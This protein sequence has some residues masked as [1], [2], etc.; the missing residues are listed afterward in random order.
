MDYLQ[1][2]Y[3]TVTT[4]RSKLRHDDALDNQLE[5]ILNHRQ[6][7]DTTYEPQLNTL[8]K[9]YQSN[10]NKNIHATKKNDKDNFH[11]TMLKDRHHRHAYRIIKGAVSASLQF[12]I[13]NTVGPLNQP[14]GTITSNPGEIDQIVKDDYNPVYQGNIPEGMTHEQHAQIFKPETSPSFFKPTNLKSSLSKGKG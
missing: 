9:Q 12:L 2:N 6:P 14:V 1:R 7:N 4:I 3:A 10:Y 13:R 11:N 8:F 5:L